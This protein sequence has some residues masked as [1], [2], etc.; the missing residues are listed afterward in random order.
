MNMRRHLL[1]LTAMLL[2][3]GAVTA[4]VQEGEWM[5][6][7]DAYRS[8]VVFEKYGKPKNLIQNHLQVMARDKGVPMDGLQLALSGKGT[9]LTL[10][11]DATGRTVFP[12]LKAAYDDNAALVLNRKGGQYAFRSRVSIVVRPD[13]V[14]DLGELRAACEQALAFQRTV[15]GAAKA[16]HCVGVRFA[17]A[18]RGGDVVV[19][20]RRWRDRLAGA[21]RRGLCGRPL[22]GLPH[23]QC[24]FHGKPRQGAGGDAERAAVD[25]G[26]GGIS[27]IRPRPTARTDSLRPTPS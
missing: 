3:A 27:A 21:R 9:Q 23:R 7:R 6:Y 13:G 4:Q 11:L 20:L 10:P 15:D 12:L 26:A 1:A 17:F 18:R 25:R 5:S 8:M 24:A 16:R 19:K 2:A 14:Y 22:R